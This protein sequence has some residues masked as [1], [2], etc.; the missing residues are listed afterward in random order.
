MQAMQH[1]QITAIK[2]DTLQIK[3]KTTRYTYTIQF[4][5]RRIKST[6]TNLAEKHPPKTTQYNTITH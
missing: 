6:I 1:I 3:H 5:Q 4:S 2:Y